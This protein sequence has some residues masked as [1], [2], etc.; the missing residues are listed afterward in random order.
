[1]TCTKINDIVYT[2]DRY[3]IMN[4]LSQAIKQT[5]GGIAE[6]L[7]IDSAT[8]TVCFA[9]G[10]VIGILAGISIFIISRW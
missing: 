6:R 10:A 5:W 8:L 3:E 9:V 1:M 7:G 2:R 4:V